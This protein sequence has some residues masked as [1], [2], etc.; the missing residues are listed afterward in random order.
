VCFCSS[1]RR[2]TSK[3]CRVPISRLLEP[4]LRECG[5][6]TT[7]GNRDGVCCG[8]S[9]VGSR[10]RECPHSPTRTGVRSSFF[11]AAV[12]SNEIRRMSEAKA[13]ASESKK[14]K[15]DRPPTSFLSLF[16][17]PP[18]NRVQKKAA[19]PRWYAH[20]LLLLKLS[21]SLSSAESSRGNQACERESKELPSLSLAARD[22]RRRFVVSGLSPGSARALRCVYS[23]LCHIGGVLVAGE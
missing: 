21:F 10:D 23:S 1:T 6:L 16:G 2:R 5:A 13:R 11:L 17:H 12:S 8:E 7:K 19:T 9:S 15:L 14:K 18:L 20:T 4:C 3:D 22:R